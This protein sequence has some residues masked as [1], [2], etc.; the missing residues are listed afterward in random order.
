MSEH[1]EYSDKVWEIFREY[2]GTIHIEEI[3]EIETKTQ[4][5][6]EKWNG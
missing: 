1:K 5:M 4:M 2:G 6:E 3:A